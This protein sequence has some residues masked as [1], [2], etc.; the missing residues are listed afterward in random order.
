MAR[1]MCEEGRDWMNLSLAHDVLKRNRSRGVLTPPGC[2]LVLAEHP[3]P[4]ERDRR[5]VPV[6]VVLE[7]RYAFWLWLR[8]KKEMLSYDRVSGQ[9]TADRDFRPPDLL[10]MDRHDDIG[11]SCDF[12]EDELRRLN[13]QDENE[14]GFFCWAGLRPLNDGHV[15]PAVWLNAIGDVYAITKQRDD[16]QC[17]D[18]T[19]SDRY[20]REHRITYL[21]RPADFFALWV[22]DGRGDGLL[23]DIDLDYFTR[24][25]EVPDQSYTPMLPDRAI[26][27]E[28]DPSQEWVREVLMNLRGL[29]IAL[30]PA[31]TGGL[32]NSLHLLRQWEKAFFDVP[33]SDKECSWRN[34]FG[35]SY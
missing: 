15:A 8:V 1:T 11:G 27:D 24:A 7:H 29:T 12:I 35:P 19:I 6:G 25:E 32:T 4:R 10:T 16:S 23:W 30:E 22:K 17:E 31:Y 2:C 28:L 26:A 20:G 33:L 13:Q 21:Q 5:C 14:V 34:F 9:R 18:R 3:A